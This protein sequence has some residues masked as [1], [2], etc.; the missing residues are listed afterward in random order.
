MQV[1]ALEKFH[2]D[3]QEALCGVPKQDMV[4]I[5]RD[6]NARVGCDDKAWP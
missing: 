1:E 5:M 2:E 3:L 6:F 4:F